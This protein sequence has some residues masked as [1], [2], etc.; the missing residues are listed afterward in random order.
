MPFTRPV[1]PIHG[2]SDK[3]QSFAA[4]RQSLIALGVNYVLL[5]VCTCISLNNEV[6]IIDIGETLDRALE[7]QLKWEEGQPT[8]FDTIAQPAG[9]LV[10]SSWLVRYGPRCGRLKYL[11]RLA[12]ATLEAV[13]NFPIQIG[14]FRSRWRPV[15]RL[16]LAISPVMDRFWVRGPALI[17]LSV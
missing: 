2:Y 1:V 7:Y 13:S 11:V 14:R 17:S 6:T 9:M 16:E 12:P 4:W 5:D 15:F 3:G 8:E 10:L